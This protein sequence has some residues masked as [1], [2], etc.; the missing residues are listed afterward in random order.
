MR[1]LLTAIAI[2]VIT[3]VLVATGRAENVVPEA[4]RGVAL[5]IGNSKYEHIAP[6]ANPASDADAVER[7]LSDLGFDSV[8]RS[9]R[10]AETL[11][12]DL[13]RFIEDAEGADA[14]ILYYAGHG[15]EAG[16]EN[17]L[18]PVDAD[19]S[20]LEAAAQRLVPLSWVIERL[21]ATVPIAI[22]LLDACRD[23]PFPPGALVKASPDGPSAPI[24]VAG[25][26][27]TRGGAAL[28]RT[29][30][31]SI[32]SYGT[33]IGFAA[34]P[35]AKALDG[36]PGGNSPYAAALIRHFE[37]MTG[38]EFGL[39]MRMVAE[40]VYLQTEGR[41]RPWINESLRRLLY[42]GRSRPEQ[43]AAEHKIIVER[44]G[45]L[46]QVASLDQATKNE[47][48]RLASIDAVPAAAVFAAL[49]AEGYLDAGNA[50]LASD[51]QEQ[52]QHLKRMIAVQSVIEN[53]DPELQ[54]LTS[55]SRQAVREGALNVASEIRAQI[56]GVIDRLDAQLSQQEEA[57]TS[58]RIELAAAQA[59]SGDVALLVYDYDGAA[60]YYAAAAEQIED[61][62]KYLY[63]KYLNA[64]AVAHQYAAMRSGRPEAIDAS[65][66]SAIQALEVIDK[67]IHPQEW[68][69]AQLNLGS[70]LMV[71]SGLSRN[72]DIQEQ[73][74]SRYDGLPKINFD[75]FELSKRSAII[76]PLAYIAN[77][78]RYLSDGSVDMLSLMERSKELARSLDRISRPVEWAYANA[79]AATIAGV[80]AA[81]EPAEV[82]QRAAWLEQTRSGFDLA[83][84][85][86]TVDRS[87]MMTA[88]LELEWARATRELWRITESQDHADQA[89]NGFELALSTLRSWPDSVL[90]FEA[91]TDHGQFL[92]EL[93]YL[94]GDADQLA[95]AIEAF[96]EVRD[97]RDF[98]TDP[99]RWATAQFALAEALVELGQ[100][101]FEAE[102]IVDGQLLVRAAAEKLS[103]SGI[104]DSELPFDDFLTWTETVLE[105]I[106]E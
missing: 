93:A 4:L 84:Q 51:V 16:G 56:A 83:R 50:N 25:L 103:E 5:V 28:G 80:L 102:P 41:Q 100:W 98:D 53:P 79:L 10:D 82:S 94:S 15:V 2:A 71:S 61:H 22:V 85:V 33:V 24:S 76:S 90:W 86:L 99:L 78:L 48:V 13:E 77:E 73:G 44:R 67:A 32:D 75:Q 101:T 36:E 106:E 58:R 96:A 95:R 60:R 87:G 35:G 64:K 81:N 91:R 31:R 97:R 59:E 19:M 39:V 69:I 65:I 45:L 23:N 38:E 62:D 105:E 104:H 12:R 70:A 7:L 52:V 37:A 29:A 54:E 66:M 55:L 27:A 8:R 92:M 3:A 17:W 18:I 47:I 34:E 72:M 6:L 63:W 74:R 43:Q 20:A 68:A 89:M 14:A 40:E 26:A 11:V 57:I 42:F 88:A 1:L 9:D 49:V 21:Q 30:E 46:L